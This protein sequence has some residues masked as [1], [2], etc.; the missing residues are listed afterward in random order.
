MKNGV[1]L[2]GG[3][4]DPIHNGH[5]TIT[6]A[7][8]EKLGLEKVILIPSAAPPHK[9]AAAITPA[10]HRFAMAAA[11]AQEDS[12]FQVS[13]CELQR[14]GPS[15][16]LDTVCHFRALLGPDSPLYWLIGADSITE[17]PNWYHITQLLDECTLAIAARPGY[18]LGNWPELRPALNDR[19][20]AQLQ[21]YTLDTPLVD[22]SATDIR[23]RVAQGLPISDLVPHPVERYIAQHRLYLAG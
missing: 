4:F 15:Y 2:F 12:L 1:L 7:A 3:T 9:P 5:L 22:I 13:D 23:R 16:T 18:P 14:T 11:A 19:Q 21:E 20:I 10:A 17:L 6:R 8:A